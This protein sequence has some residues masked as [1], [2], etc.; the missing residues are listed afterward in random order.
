MGNNNAIT[1][2]GLDY[3]FFSQTELPAMRE[4][5]SLSNLVV[6]LLVSNLKI[7]TFLKEK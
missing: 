3:F 5:T 7:Y 1:T 2:L 4:S 6:F